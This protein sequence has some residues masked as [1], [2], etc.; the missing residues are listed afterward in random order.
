MSSLAALLA[1]SKPTTNGPKCFFAVLL[2]TLDDVDRKALVQALAL[3][4]GMQG[5]QISDV[6]TAQGHPVKS[7][8]VQWHRNGR[9]ACE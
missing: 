1:A 5:Q 9:C 2:P 3:G 7:H 4:S 6:L 8:T